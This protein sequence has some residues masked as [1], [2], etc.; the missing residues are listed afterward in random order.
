MYELIVLAL[1]TG[2]TRVVTFMLG[3]GGSN[4]SYRF[5]GVPEG[6]HD[7]SHHGKQEEKL[8]SIA[9]INRFH[10]EQFATFVGRLQA[11]RTQAGDLLEQS[12]VVFAS[13]L[14]DGNRHNHDDLPV[15][16]AG[17]GAGAVKAQ[18]HV[19]LGKETPMANL[20]LAIAQGMGVRAASFAD[21]TGVL[22][23]K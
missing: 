4:R 11:A 6:H 12:F 22:G 7:L 9:K 17:G 16:L 19:A 2:K 13:G 23:L 10:A 21:S 8:Q 15:L 14:G 1:S 5:L 3:N 18:G 20:Y